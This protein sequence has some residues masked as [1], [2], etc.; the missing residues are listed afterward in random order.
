MKG[1]KDFRCSKCNKLLGKIDGR[2]EIVCTR[3][4][5]LNVMK[6]ES[7]DMLKKRAELYKRLIESGRAT[8]N[9]VRQAEGLEPIESGDTLLNKQ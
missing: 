5:S 1:L 3:C 2:A 4:K 7:H 9:E 6:G 8:M